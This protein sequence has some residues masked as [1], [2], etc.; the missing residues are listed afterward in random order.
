MK[1]Y[2]FN[3]EKGTRQIVK[4]RKNGLIIDSE[5]KVILALGNV[6]T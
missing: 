5:T 6:N 3:S 1:N 2:Y 4:S